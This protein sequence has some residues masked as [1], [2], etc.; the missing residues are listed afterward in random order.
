M[1]LQPETALRARLIA[2]G[3]VTAILGERIYP[4]MPTQST[5]FPYVVVG[6]SQS[7]Y[8]HKMGA[9]SA[10]TLRE[11]DIQFAAYGTSEQ[12]DSLKSLADEIRDS[13]NGFRGTITVSAD[14]IAFEMCH[15]KNEVDGTLDPSDGTGTPLHFWE[16]TYRIAYQE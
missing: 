8:H 2:D 16:Q 7:D 14:S 10:A 11:H 9:D 5:A 12:Y 13:L 4:H 6:R 3:S 15:C 1:A